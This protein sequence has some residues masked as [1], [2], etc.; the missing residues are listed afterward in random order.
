MICHLPGNTSISCLEVELFLMLSQISFV[1][2][3][4]SAS[5]VPPLFDMLRYDIHMIQLECSLEVIIVMVHP[6]I[7]YA[8]QKSTGKPSRCNVLLRLFL[9]VWWI[10]DIGL[11]Y[12]LNARLYHQ[13]IKRFYRSI[14]IVQVSIQRIPD[15]LIGYKT[16]VIWYS[17][18]GGDL[19]SETG[20]LK[21][22]QQNS[23]IS[24]MLKRE[25]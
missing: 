7:I 12:W 23:R 4:V 19:M 9:G 1:C 10:I 24:I 6:L 5:N 14:N 18:L 3:A 17:L 2:C 21:N 11:I 13:A 8:W 15:Y 25:H 16:L 22:M 20:A